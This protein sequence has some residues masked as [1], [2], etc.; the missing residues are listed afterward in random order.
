M[1]NGRV[2]IGSDEHRELFCRSFIETHD[3]Y[4]PAALPWPDL[5]EIS[6]KRLR[7]VPFWGTALQ[8]ERNAG[9]MVT[10]FAE[11]LEDPLIREAVA[12]QGFEENR[13]AVMMR[14]LVN[15]YGL[16][17]EIDETLPAPTKR[18]FIDF[19]YNECLDS[20]FGFGVFRLARE[21][22]VLPINLITLFTRVL[23]E[24]ARHIVFFVNWIAYDRARRGYRG[25]LLQAPGTAWGYYRSLRRLI[26]LARGGRN[27]AESRKFGEAFNEVS[28][29][30]LTL[31]DFVAACVTENDEVMA[32][33]DTRL[34]RPRL[35]PNIARFALRFMRKPRRGAS[36]VERGP[37]ER[38]DGLADRLEDRPVPLESDGAE[39]VA[40]VLG[41]DNEPSEQQPAIAAVQPQLREFGEKNRTDGV[42][43]V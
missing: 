14:T 42:D 12:L 27:N 8:I 28:F 16:H 1:R 6:L 22:E 33:L 30:N 17:A 5:D 20:F 18:A 40:N 37:L 39:R 15:R 7:A 11:T 2:R 9:Y 24:E 21:A 26:D 4:D 25:A 3:G 23:H 43:P 41:V 29:E 19:G 34:L 31:R 10:A 35:I 38:S 13:H 36:S 32:Q